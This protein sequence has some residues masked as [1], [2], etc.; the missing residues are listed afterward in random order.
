MRYI[1]VEYIFALVVLSHTVYRRF[2]LTGSNDNFLT[3]T[4]S[5]FCNGELRA[6][7]EYSQTVN[8]AA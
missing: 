3:D 2:A 7:G 1:W 6:G 8:V 4:S 5:T